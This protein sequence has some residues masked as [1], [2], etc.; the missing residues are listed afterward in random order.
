MHDFIYLCWLRRA[1]IDMSEN[2]GILKRYLIK[3]S[4]GS[5]CCSSSLLSIATQQ[6]QQQTARGKSC[7]SSGANNNKADRRC[8]QQVASWKSN[9][10]SQFGE[11]IVGGKGEGR[12]GAHRRVACPAARRTFHPRGGARGQPAR[13]HVNVIST[14]KIKIK[15]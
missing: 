11:N 4:R 12:L 8:T 2:V 6:R 1:K 7:M 3:G 15:H 13:R 10:G 9:S 5:I 14:T